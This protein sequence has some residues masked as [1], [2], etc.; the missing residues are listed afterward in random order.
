M[1]PTLSLS[2]PRRASSG[3][4]PSSLP[5]LAWVLVL[6]AL[7]AAMTAAP[8][9]AGPKIQN[10]QTPAGT[11]VYFVE[12]HALPMLDVQVD[13]SAGAAY[14][15]PGKSGVSSLTAGL[16]DGGTAGR[17]GPLDEAAIS[18]RLADLGALLRAGADQDRTSVSLRTL[19]APAQREP[20]LALLADVLSAPSFPVAVFERDRARTVSAL[21]DSLTQPETLAVRAFWRTLYP[22]HPYGA[23][24][25]PEGLE[26]LTRDDLLTFWRGHY[27]ADR[28]VI[29]LVG[30]LSRQDAEAIALG[31][32]QGLP[33]EGAA[34]S[35]TLPA[36]A[37]VQGGVVSEAH[38]ATQAHLYLGMPAIAKGDPDFFPLM[39][40]NYILG[41][42]GFVSRLTKEVREKRGYAYSVYSTFAPLRGPGPFYI[43]LQ[44]KRSQADEAL[45]VVRETLDR[46]LAEGPTAAELQA[47]KAN[48]EG[49]FPLRLDTSRK[50][51][52]NVANIGFYGLPLDY[53]DTYTRRVEAVSV[54][55][56]RAAFARHVKAGQ[57]VT[58]KVAAE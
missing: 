3:T 46:F 8:A 36:V 34:A 44:T 11:R 45:K 18:N 27:R 30:D 28:A 58:V 7:I 15:P 22:G 25:T 55:D 37:P 16:L 2:G 42:G 1:M 29:T 53:L 52:D 12:S 54:A 10:W 5:G 35:L 13:F 56:I 17:L 26:G 4:S 49:G 24:S 9:W 6:L 19:S 38:P 50:L 43:S 47:A 48:L 57:L 14:D 51:L 39:V 20:A 23:Q 32:T 41:G 31:L 33:Q 21:K 40:G